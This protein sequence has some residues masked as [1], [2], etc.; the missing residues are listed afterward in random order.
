MLHPNDNNPSNNLSLAEYLI[1]IRASK[2]ANSITRPTES[3]VHNKSSSTFS[4]KN[5]NEKFYRKSFQR[6]NNVDNQHLD[7][8]KLYYFEFPPEISGMMRSNCQYDSPSSSSSITSQIT[9]DSSFGDDEQ[10]NCS[11]EVED[12]ARMLVDLME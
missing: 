1:R 3:M 8:T 5:V 12:G 10:I 6:K 7:T 2:R 11:M 4:S 9:G